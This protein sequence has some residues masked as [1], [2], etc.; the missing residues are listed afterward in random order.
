M[1]TEDDNAAALAVYAAT[2]AERDD[3]GTVMLTYHHGP[4]DGDPP[5]SATALTTGAE[6][7]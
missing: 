5:L 7:R 4:A 3:P 1:L 6:S 2:G